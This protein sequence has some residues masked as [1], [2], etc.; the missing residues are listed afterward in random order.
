MIVDIHTHFLDLDRD[1]GKQVIA[2]LQ[3]CGIAPAAWRFTPEDHLRATQAADFAVVFGLRAACT[4]WHVPNEAVAEHVARAPERLI[5]FAAIDPGQPGFMGEL[6]RCHRDLG[7]KGVK[8][9]PIYQGVHPLDRRCREIYGYCQRHGLP[10][11]AHMAT[12]FSSGVP[13]E[14]ARPA[15]MDQVA[16]EFADLNIVLAHMSHPW[17]G[18]AIA[19]IRKQPNLY[20]DIS[21]LYYR[22]WQFYNTMRLVVEYG[23]ER[24]VLFG[25]DFPATKTADSIAGLRNVN[26]V[27]AESGLPRIPEGV[28]ED[29][30]HQDS[31][32]LL[33]IEP[34]AAKGTW[35]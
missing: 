14:Y 6:E 24:K 9:G 18:E 3:R 26:A 15:H 25:S 13:L 23:A 28:I 5:F 1:C 11:L 17:E 7:C 8:L 35:A 22:P 27:I 30:I 21:A 4:G 19:A 20:A 10:V 31:L 33:A 34:P 12:T 2:D 29:I 16:C 32:R